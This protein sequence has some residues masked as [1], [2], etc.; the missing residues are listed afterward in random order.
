[1]SKEAIEREMANFN[2][3]RP[4]ARQ[5]NLQDSPL[6]HQ[7]AKIK[8]GIRSAM[9][10]LKLS[11]ISD[12]QRDALRLQIMEAAKSD[13]SEIL[14]SERCRVSA[15]VAKLEK[16]Y[17]RDAELNRT[18]Y[19]SELTRYSN[20]VAAMDAD[21]L[22]TEMLQAVSGGI[23][24]RPEALDV[25]S[26]ELKHTAPTDHAMLRS[27]IREKQ[28]D[29]PWLHQPEG[30]DLMQYASVLDQN[31]KN[32]GELPQVAEGYVYATTLEQFVEGDV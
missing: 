31:L 27:T 32:S 8:D 20:R 25:L 23:S 16:I 6:N 28:M 29:K 4:P 13:L 14:Q 19:D 17:N 22:K 5:S 12:K 30:R 18:R 21:E 24:L 2:K 1:M 7:L 11:G 9:A 10:E 3:N 26:R 15:E